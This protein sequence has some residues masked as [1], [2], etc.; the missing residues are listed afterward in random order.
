MEKRR[1]RIAFSSTTYHQ[2]AC[3][4]LYAKFIPRCVNSCACRPL[5][6]RLPPRNLG[7]SN[8]RACR[9]RDKSLS[10]SL[11]ILSTDR[12]YRS[13]TFTGLKTPWWKEGWGR[14][15]GGYFRSTR[16]LQQWEVE[17]RCF[18]DSGVLT[19]CLWKQL[20]HCGR[21]WAIVTRLDAST[22]IG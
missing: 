13:N 5:V 10:L 20:P 2:G 17:T 3:K 6:Y 4:S 12:F 21:K 9:S 8:D 15:I 22:I 19:R 16:G 11:S 1:G 14:G 18:R 7:L